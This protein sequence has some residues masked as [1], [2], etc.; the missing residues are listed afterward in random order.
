MSNEFNPYH[1]WLG[2]PLKDQPADYYRLLGVT[3]FENDPDVITGASDQR[4]H[5]LRTLQTGERGKLVDKLL[6]EIA[7]AKVCLLNKEKK[8]A[9]DQ[10][11]R[12]KTASP[13]QTTQKALFIRPMPNPCRGVA[14]VI[15]KARG[16][17][18]KKKINPT[19]ARSD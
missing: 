4:M 17:T 19:D 2:I 3:Q 1:K 10:K 8:A 15:Q 12:G 16:V 6:N 14:L 11:L 9:Y 5:F 7:N 13:K 18:Q